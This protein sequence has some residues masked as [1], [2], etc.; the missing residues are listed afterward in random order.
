MS[1]A[2]MS[3]LPHRIKASLTV[4]AVVL[5]IAFTSNTFAFEHSSNLEL[6]ITN[7]TYQHDI[8]ELNALADS[9]AGYN[10]AYALYRLAQVNMPNEDKSAVIA[11]LNDALTALTPI[12]DPEAEVL[13]AAI[14]G[15]LM[16]ADPKSAS[17]LYPQVQQ[18]LTAAKAHKSAKPRALLIEGINAFYVP[19]AFGGGTEK[20]RL[21]FKEAL[22][23]YQSPVK[24]AQVSW[25]EVETYIWLGQ[26]LEQEGQK[27]EARSAYEEA[28]TLAPNCTWAK[29][30]LSQLNEKS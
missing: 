20:A 29:H 8:P 1:N 27:E 28:L 19:P 18:T 3:R 16:G 17:T 24:N 6:A 14:L 30:Q 23:Y 22:S 9:S 25:G 7:A 10:K 12:S 13:K 5:A 4:T 26:V 2:T 15:L 11:H 21:L